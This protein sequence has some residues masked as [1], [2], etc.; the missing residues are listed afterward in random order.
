MENMFDSFFYFYFLKNTK[1]KEQEH[2]L[3]IG[4]KYSRCSL[5]HSCYLNLVVYV[6]LVFITISEYW[7]P[8]MFSM[9]SLFSLFFRTKTRK[10]VNKRLLISDIIHK[11]DKLLNSVYTKLFRV[12]V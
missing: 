3:K 5:N 11:L 6:F 10:T 7:E 1:F 2:V 9:F 4:T 8:N 12:F